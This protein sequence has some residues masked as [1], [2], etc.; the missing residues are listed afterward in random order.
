MKSEKQT[1]VLTVRVSRRLLAVLRERCAETHADTPTGKI[2]KIVKPSGM[3][4]KI[5]QRQLIGHRSFN[6]GEST[7]S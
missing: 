5:L 6:G 7:S 3:A 1:E 4:R 2:R